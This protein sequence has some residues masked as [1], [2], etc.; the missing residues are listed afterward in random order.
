LSLLGTEL[1]DGTDDA[2]EG[3]RLGDFD[4]VG[5][6][7]LDGVR[8]DPLVLGIILIVG[9]MLGIGNCCPL[10]LGVTD[11]LTLGL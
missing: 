8:L 9:R 11:G 4:S 6:E 2:A 5:I 3:N 10:P 1:A 7:L